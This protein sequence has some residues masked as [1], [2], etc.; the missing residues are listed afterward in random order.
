MYNSQDNINM[1]VKVMG[2]DDADWT[3]LTH[4]RVQWR[5]IFNMVMNIGVP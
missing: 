4:D 1:D 3:H 5:G 2:C